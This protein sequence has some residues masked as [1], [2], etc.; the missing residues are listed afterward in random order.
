MTQEKKL[1]FEQLEILELNATLEISEDSLELFINRIQHLPP[2]IIQHV[3]YF[4]PEYEKFIEQAKHLKKPI[5]EIQKAIQ[6]QYI[7][8]IKTKNKL[9]KTNS[10]VP[11][12]SKAETF[13]SSESLPIS[14]DLYKIIPSITEANLLQILQFF[15]PQADFTKYPTGLHENSFYTSNQIE[16][17]K[18]EINKLPPKEKKQI[19]NYIENILEQTAINFA[20]NTKAI[21]DLIDGEHNPHTKST[22]PGQSRPK[23]TPKFNSSLSE[24]PK[25][26]VHGLEPHSEINYQPKLTPEKTKTFPNNQI[27]KNP[28][29]K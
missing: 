25:T 6:T 8:A 26:P 11:K 20:N 10:Q 21:H 14:I 24:Y 3:F 2:N 18:I 23:E 15:K 22:K 29:K 5:S 19:I 4:I 9:I 13:D 28:F 27:S 7:E 16:K 1:A 17:I 12:K